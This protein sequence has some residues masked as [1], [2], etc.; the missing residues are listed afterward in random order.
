MS[1]ARSTRSRAFVSPRSRTAP[2]EPASSAPPIWRRSCAICPVSWTPGSSSTPP[3][4]TTPRYFCCLPIG[5]WSRRWTSSRPSSTTRQRG[6][7]SRSANALSDIYAMGATP[8]FGLNLVGWP[9]DRLPFEML[10]EVLRGAA[11]VAERA[12][13]SRSRAAI[14]STAVEPMFGMAVIGEVHPDRMLTNAGACAG[15]RSGAD[16]AARAPG[17]WPPRSS[18]TRCSRPGWRTRCGR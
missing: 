8:L 5:P 2:V 14:R 12:K 15:D 9:R 4:G 6:A 10:G 11:E 18:V 17:S 3:P 13:M 16:Q 1:D 7:R